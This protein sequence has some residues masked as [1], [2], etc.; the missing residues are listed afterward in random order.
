MKRIFNILLVLFFSIVGIELFSEAMHWKIWMFY[1]KPFILPLLA[2]LFWIKSFQIPINIRW[3][4]MGSLVFAWI[5][6]ISLLLTPQDI[7]DTEIAGV[8]KSK[9][10]FLLGLSAFLIRHLFIFPV[11]SKPVSGLSET[12]FKTKKIYFLP[13]L[14]YF[15]LMNVIIAPAVYQNPDKSIATIPVIIYSAVLV[16]MVAFALNRYNAV[17]AKSF[18][19]VFFGALLF[20]FSDSLI[21]INFLALKTPMPYAGFVIF[22]TYIVSEVLIIFGL[23]E[24]YKTVS[25]SR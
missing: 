9:Y 12:L 14:L 20:L 16:S 18:N 25:T 24:E 15:I 13:L 19:M 10:Y 22:F 17:S 23:L 11:F 21:G 6:D 3:L 2:L 4:I 8:P 7:H 5:G 1:S